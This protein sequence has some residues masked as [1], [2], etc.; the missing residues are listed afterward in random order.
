MF[1]SSSGFTCKL[2]AVY[3]PEIKVQIIHKWNVINT[4]DIAHTDFCLDV[5]MIRDD[6]LI[7]FIVIFYQHNTSNSNSVCRFSVQF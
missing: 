3:C 7:V 1:L 4:L 2:F 6:I 5:I